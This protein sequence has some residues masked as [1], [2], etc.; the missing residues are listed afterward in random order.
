MAANDRYI[1]VCL[2]SFSVVLLLFIFILVVCSFRSLLCSS[3]LPLIDVCRM[4]TS[5]G[6]SWSS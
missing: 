4:A 2:S 1:N 6:K 3:S 5:L